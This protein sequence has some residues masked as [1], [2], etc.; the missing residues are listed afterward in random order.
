MTSKWHHLR[1]SILL[2]CLIQ[3]I[4]P[5][6]STELYNWF[7]YLTNHCK[8]SVLFNQSGANQTQSWLGW[9]AFSRAW[10]RSRVFA[11]CSDWFFELS[12]FVVIGPIDFFSLMTIVRNLLCK[13]TQQKVQTASFRRQRSDC[14][15]FSMWKQCSSY[16]F[17]FYRLFEK[18]YEI[19]RSLVHKNNCIRSSGSIFSTNVV[20]TSIRNKITYLPCSIN[21]LIQY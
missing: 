18:V 2:F 6:S 1:M 15:S 5:E 3:T 4:F 16:N 19:I 14:V 8:H 12:A 20:L 13:H 9:C 7:K 17:Y 21:N 11:S 10:H